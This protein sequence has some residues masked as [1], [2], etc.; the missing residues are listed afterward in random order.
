MPFR[1]RLVTSVYTE[2]SFVVVRPFV[3]TFKLRGMQHTITVPKGFVTDFAS[4]PWIVQR[5]PGFDV[6]GDSR[7]AA[8]VHDYLYCMQGVVSVETHRVDSVGVVPATFSRLE[9]DEIFKQAIRDTGR[10]ATTRDIVKGS[11]SGLQADL[12]YAGVRVGGR[13]YW[14]KRKGGPDRGDFATVEYMKT[15]EISA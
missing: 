4:I 12:F 13:A 14:N 2:G 8:V 6:N 9:C 1:T 5:I 10:D 7:F 15:L 11:Y 3:Y